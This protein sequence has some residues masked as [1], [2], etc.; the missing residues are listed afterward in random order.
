[1]KYKYE[2]SKTSLVVLYSQNYVGTTTNVQ[3]ILNN[4]KNPNLNPA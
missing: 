1:M 4:P 3:I 2:N